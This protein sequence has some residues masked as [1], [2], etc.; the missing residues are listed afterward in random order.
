MVVVF[1][2]RITFSVRTRVNEKQRAGK[3]CRS[4]KKLLGL[5]GKI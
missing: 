1:Q 5:T 3:S 2:R 4:I